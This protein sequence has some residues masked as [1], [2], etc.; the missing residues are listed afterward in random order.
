MTAGTTRGA[1]DA[2]ALAAE[3]TAAV[4]QDVRGSLDGAAAVCLDVPSSVWVAAATYLRDSVGLD[5]FDWLSAV[6]CTDKDPAGVEIVLHVA[7]SRSGGGPRMRRVLLRAW[8]PDPGPHLPSLTGVYPGTAFHER[9][10]FE[11]FGVVFDGFEDDMGPLRPLLLPDGFEGTP[12]R[13]S[14][15]LASRAIKSWPGAKEPGEAE[16]GGPSRKKMQP[17]GV[18]DPQMWGPKP[19]P[20]APAPSPDPG[21]VDG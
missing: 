21:A 7:D 14:F 6:D 11:M 13:K 17:P 4:G 15:V 3:L 1:L 10:T 12:L 9:E 19:L 8:V 18:P 5:Y 2:A 16:G 20:G